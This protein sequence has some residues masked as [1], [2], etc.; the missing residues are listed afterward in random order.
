MKSSM[1]AALTLS[2]SGCYVPT[3]FSY[4]VPIENNTDVASIFCEDWAKIGDNLVKSTCHIDNQHSA[5]MKPIE[6]RA[7]DKNGFIIGTA[8]LG[9]STIGEKIRINKAMIMERL[10]TPAR[11]TLEITPTL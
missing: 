7:Y 5:E 4:D 9:K 8:D 2:L 11:M 3:N 1:L 10:E 6:I